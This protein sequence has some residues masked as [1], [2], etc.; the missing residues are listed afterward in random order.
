MSRTPEYYQMENILKVCVFGCTDTGKTE[1]YFRLRPSAHPY[2]S[3]QLFLKR[4][5]RNRK[6][7]PSW[8]DHQF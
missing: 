8:W 2:S 4:L 1:V 6:H 5:N 7:H 3:P